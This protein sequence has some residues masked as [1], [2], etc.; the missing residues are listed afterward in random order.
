[1]TFITE[2]KPQ[3]EDFL[4]KQ[5]C[6]LETYT[7]ILNTCYDGEVHSMPQHKN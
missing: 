4:A 6:F 3:K 1:M 7:S 2:I 5:D